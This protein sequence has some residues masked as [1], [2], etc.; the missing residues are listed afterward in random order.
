MDIRIVEDDT[1]NTVQ[2]SF[3]MNATVAC[4]MDFH[5]YPADIQLCPLI[6]QSCRCFY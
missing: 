4:Q 2:L 1:N 5:Y 6:M 3:V